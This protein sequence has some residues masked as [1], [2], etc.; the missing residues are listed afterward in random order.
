MIA[1]AKASVKASMPSDRIGRAFVAAAII[2][3]VTWTGL[4]LGMLLEHVFHVTD[5]GVAV[6]GPLHGVAFLVYVV[7]AVMAATRFRWSLGVFL[8][9]LLAAV[10]PLTTIPLEVWLRL[11]GRL[12]RPSAE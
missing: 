3:A 6:F 8:L 10:P 11:T 7:I 4:L 12:K 1:S 5:M 2:E 9:A